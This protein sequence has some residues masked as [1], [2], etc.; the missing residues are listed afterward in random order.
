MAASKIDKMPTDLEAMLAQRFRPSAAGDLDI[1][2]AL[3]TDAGE[4]LTTF[5][6]RQGVLRFDHGAVPDVTLFFGGTNPSEAPASEGLFH[7]R[8][9]GL[10]QETAPQAPALGC[11]ASAETALGIFAGSTDPMAAFMAGAFRA[12]GNLP[13]VF[14]LLDLFRGDLRATPQE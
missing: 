12:D 4:R 11:H 1:V 7:G 5:S 9:A 8:A 2:V 10:G 13:L 6:V 3:A 14:V